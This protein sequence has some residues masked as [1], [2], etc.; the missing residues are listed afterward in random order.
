LTKAAV[1]KFQ[2]KYAADCLASWGLTTGTGYVG[3]TT[4]AKLNSLL[5]AGEEEEEEEEEEEVPESGVSVTLA[6]DT[7]TTNALPYSASLVPYLKVNFTAAAEGDVTIN[8]LAFT[9]VGA[10]EAGDF[11]CVYLYDG[12]TRLTYCRT[13]S[14]STSKVTFSG[15]NYVVKAGKTATLTVKADLAGIG[16]LGKI[17]AFQI[18]S[19]ADITTSAAV[20]G[21]F[22]ITGNVMTIVNVA[23]GTVAIAKVNISDKALKVGETQQI[24]AAFK[25]DTTGSNENVLLESIRIK[26][27][28]AADPEDLE[29]FKV[30]A[31]TELIAE[32]ESTDSDYLDI[33]PDTP[34]KIEKG[35]SKSFKVRADIVGG[36]AA[37]AIQYVLDETTD[38]VAIGATYGFAV[39]VTGA[40]TG[41]A[42][43]VD[44]GKLTVSIT[45]PAAYSVSPDADDVI[46]ATIKFITGGD[47]D[48]NVKTLYAW[49]DAT[50]NDADDV[51]ENA[52]ENVQLVNVSTGEVYD[53][54]DD[55]NTANDDFYFKVRNITLPAGSSSWNLRA[56]LIDTGTDIVE[57]DDTFVFTMFAGADQADG[58][59]STD[60]RKG[61]QAENLDGKAI[62]DIVPAADIT[63]NE[64]TISTAALTV[65]NVT[66]AAGDA[67]GN[68]AKVKLLQ[69]ALEAGTT[70]DITVTTIECALDADDDDADASNYTLWAVGESKPLQEGVSATDLDVVFDSILYTVEAGEDETLYVT[71]DIAS[72]PI[73]ADIQ[74]SLK[75]DG[76]TAEDEEGDEL[77]DAQITGDVDDGFAGR[78]VTLQANGTIEFSLASDSPSADQI[79]L[80]DSTGTYVMKVKADASF[81]DIVLKTLVFQNTGEEGAD[82]SIA[83]VSLYQDGT[84]VKT[85]TTITAAHK[86]VFNNLDTMA[87]PVVVEKD[88]DSIFSIKVDIAGIGDGPNDTADSD[89]QFAFT[90]VDADIEARGYSSNNNLADGDIT[91]DAVSQDFYVYASKVIA[92]KSANQPTTLASG[93]NEAL[94]FTLTPSTNDAKTSQLADLVV[95]VAFSDAAGDNLGIQDGVG[96]KAIEVYSGGTLIGSYSSEDLDK[97]SGAKAIDVAAADNIAAA[98][99]TYTI[100]LRVVAAGADDKITTSLNVNGGPGNDDI[101][102]NDYNGGTAVSWIDLGEGSSITVIQNTISY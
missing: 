44:A 84:L 91:T 79:V 39:G 63:G 72:V 97:T 48:V 7:P 5:A 34:Y 87:T 3:S 6:A 96:T 62:D 35:D 13:V 93:V 101:T 9:R 86:V 38:L 58:A 46:F 78:L 16:A 8:G 99:E 69:L 37:N 85:K 14:V 70:E 66:L 21:T 80:S 68:T 43:D 45:G 98:G 81:E 74:L 75:E 71:A 50:E 95:N 73:S 40:Y 36:V 61:I 92:E 26:N 31:G 24:V 29:N 76:V 49:L 10:G 2:E 59:D 42:L 52:I 65:N 77:E 102:W 11:D 53:V 33:V 56:D 94:K 25:L 88:D 41:D 23:G 60:G 100:K 51:L 82:D 55:D 54:I 12:A 89:D 17:D 47:E 20:S 30:Y 67:V 57:N 4:R 28:G 22:P 27:D 90:L 19:S 64:V 15:L 18:A 1:I 83:K 32:I